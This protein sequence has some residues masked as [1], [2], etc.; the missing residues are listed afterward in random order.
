MNQQSQ[1]TAGITSEES[2]ASRVPI[3]KGDKFR[4]PTGVW[5]VIELKPGGR[6]ELF[7]KA[8]SSFQSRYHREVRTWERMS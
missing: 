4:T 3:V 5:A 8:R 7:C 6:L 1:T 2:T